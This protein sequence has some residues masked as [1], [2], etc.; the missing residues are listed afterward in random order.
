MKNRAVIITGDRNA[1]AEVWRPVVSQAIIDIHE[2]EGKRVLIHGGASG[3]DTIA[4][5]AWSFG[6]GPDSIRVHEAEWD[7]CYRTYSNRNM[8]GPLRNDLMLTEL[9]F[10]KRM[11]WQVGVV[12]FHD[13]LYKGSRGTRNMIHI[14]QAARV[15]TIAFKS[16]GSTYGSQ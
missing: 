14:A 5:L 7:A 13:A 15:R 16:D 8:A 2:G 4:N 10:L 12:A 3:I 9:L 11:G 6:Y 1:K